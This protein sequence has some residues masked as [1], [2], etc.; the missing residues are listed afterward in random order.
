MLLLVKMRR[1]IKVNDIIQKSADISQTFIFTGNETCTYK[2]VLV[3][4]V[5]ELFTVYLFRSVL[6]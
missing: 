5:T 2:L 6:F 1:Y 4:T 3:V